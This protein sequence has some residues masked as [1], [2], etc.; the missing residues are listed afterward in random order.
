MKKRGTGGLGEKLNKVHPAAN[1]TGWLDIQSPVIKSRCPCTNPDLPT[2]H[3][4]GH[5]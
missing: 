3:P 1:N 2:H 5:C 4:E